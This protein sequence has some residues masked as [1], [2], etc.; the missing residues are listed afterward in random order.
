MGAEITRGAECTELTLET[1]LTATVVGS[2][3]DLDI[4]AV[5]FKRVQ[6]AV[7]GDKEMQ[8]LS[9]K[10]LLAKVFPHSCHYII[11]CGILYL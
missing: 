10:S 7:N 2:I 5:T 8:Q 3:S 1:D 9:L 4:R 11:S 6:D